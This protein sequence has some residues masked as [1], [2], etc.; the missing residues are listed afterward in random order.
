MKIIIFITDWFR[1][2]DS[3]SGWYSIHHEGYGKKDHSNLTRVN[4][5]KIYYYIMCIYVLN[6][7]FQ[8]WPNGRSRTISKSIMLE[9]IFRAT[10]EN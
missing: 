10:H 3:A 5:K 7:I 2:H 8:R 4:C 1:I 9:F 6:I